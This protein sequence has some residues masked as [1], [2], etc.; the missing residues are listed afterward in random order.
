[1]K[2]WDRLERKLKKSRRSKRNMV[3]AELENSIIGVLLGEWMLPLSE[4]WGRCL[5]GG[6]ER[7]RAR[8][9]AE[10]LT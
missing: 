7:I 9:S 3:V 4:G 10:K 1:M 5:K 6:F 8:L 2:K